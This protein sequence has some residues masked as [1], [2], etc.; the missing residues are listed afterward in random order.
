MMNIY[1]QNFIR[2]FFSK[3]LDI[4][5]YIAKKIKIPVVNKYHQNKAL[6]V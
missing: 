1:L 4:F 5:I 2:N 6:S 3:F